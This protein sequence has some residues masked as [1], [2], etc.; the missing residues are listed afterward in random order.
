[1]LTLGR[2]TTRKWH[3]HELELLAQRIATIV[4]HRLA[5]EAL[6]RLQLERILNER[7]VAISETGRARFEIQPLF[8]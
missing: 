1:M 6:N 2:S 4:A 3:T 8:R 7:K 5:W